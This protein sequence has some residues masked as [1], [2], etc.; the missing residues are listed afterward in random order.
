MRRDVAELVTNGQS[1]TVLGDNLFVDLDLSDANL[2]AGSLR[3][4]D[5]PPF[6]GD[7]QRAGLCSA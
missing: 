7:R 4:W 5:A 1:L 2:P 3:R 6:E